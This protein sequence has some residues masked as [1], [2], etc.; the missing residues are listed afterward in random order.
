M[1]YRQPTR[2]G[3]RAHVLVLGCLAVVG[4]SCGGS[5]GAN[6]GGGSDAGVAGVGGS[7]AGVA[8]VGGSDAGVAGV[9]GSD[10]GVAGVGGSDAGVA[11][12]GDSGGVIDVG[13]TDG[14]GSGGVNDAGSTGAGGGDGVS[15]AGS[16]SAGGTAGVNDAGSA[17]AGGSAGSTDAGSAGAAAGGGGESGSGAAGAAGGGGESGL[18]AAASGGASGQN[19]APGTGASG[20]GHGGGVGEA[21][22]GGSGEAGSGGVGQAG[23]GGVQGSCVSSSLDAVWDQGK[24]FN[25]SAGVSSLWADSPTDVWAVTDYYLPYTGPSQV[26]VQHWDGTKWATVVSGSMNREYKSLWA[27]GP[28]DLWIATSNGLLRWNG[29]S[30]AD[31]TPFPQATNGMYSVWGL[32]PNDVWANRGGGGPGIFHWDGATWMDYSAFGPV[33][34]PS[35]APSVTG[36][37]LFQPGPVW[38]ASSDDL[39]MAGIIVYPYFPIGPDSYSSAIDIVGYAHWDGVSWTVTGP[40]TLADARPGAAYSISGSSPTDIWVTGEAPGFVDHFDGTAWRR[41]ATFPPSEFY[42][43]VWASCPSNVWISGR[44]GDSGF[45]PSLRHY[46]GITWSIVPLPFLPS[47]GGLG[48]LTGVAGHDLWIGFGGPTSYSPSAGYVYHRSL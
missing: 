15:D 34:P 7:D 36:A 45:S 37:G 31:V 47:I 26:T 43:H 9:G 17:S 19:G 30:M 1:N 12:V 18:G 3:V 2:L 5:G 39:W 4:V 24:G 41:S 40:T 6:G 23:S 32:G 38:G 8:G 14:G 42:T 21:G 28:N 22:S 13:S 11:G 10:A 48:G 27:S 25:T 20:A 29:A 33:P 16:A 46:D 44:G 35:D